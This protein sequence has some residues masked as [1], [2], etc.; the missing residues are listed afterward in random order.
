MVNRLLFLFFIYILN[1]E[2]AICQLRVLGLFSDNM[3]L[4]REEPISI[5]GTA[6]PGEEVTVCLCTTV[7]SCH[8]DKTGHWVVWL[9]A[10]KAGGPYELIIRTTQDTLFYKNVLVGDVWFASGQSNMEHPIEGWKWLPNSYIYRSEEELADSDYPEIRLFTVPK[11]PA[12]EEVERM[13]EAN[14]ELCGPESLCSFS[15]T[16]WFFA[17]ALHRKL[18]VPIGI[19]NCSWAGTSIRAWESRDVLEKFRDSLN[20]TGTPYIPERSVVI[21]A[22]RDNQQRRCRISIPQEGQIKNIRRLPATAWSPIDLFKI[23][24]D[25]P[26]VIWLKK[27]IDIPERYAK[28]TLVL[29][30]GLLNRQSIVYFNGREIGEYM[31]P[32]PAVALV[33]RSCICPGKNEVIIRLA[34][35]FGLP[36]VKGWKDLFS[37]STREKDFRTD[38]SDGWLATV[39]DTIPKPK[40]EYQNYPGALFNGM[41]YPCLSYPVKGV[42][43]Y[44]G[45]NDVWQLHLYAEMFKSL[46]LDWREKWKKKDL[47]FIYVQISLLPEID[48]DASKPSYQLFREKQNVEL[49]NTGMVYSLDIGDPYD[50]HPRNKKVI[51]ERLAEQALQITFKKHF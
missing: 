20:F 41:V 13:P 2:P 17:K 3:V 38:L 40:A 47:P 50:V 30:L 9:P 8:A 26:E 1:P 21:N 23:R 22:V 36:S 44:Q 5:R 4:Q 6:V 7:V 31:Y 15:S 24:P 34:Q 27:E 16:A 49:P 25:V 32:E 28:E 19:I 35:P 14:W 43:W 12:S 46:I 29:S 18:G 42:I 11:Y 10:E 37:I 45:E 39:Q 48:P 33:S 51:G